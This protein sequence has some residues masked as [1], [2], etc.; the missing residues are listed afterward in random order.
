MKYF[1]AEY[2]QKIFNY[3]T[4]NQIP[5][6]YQECPWHLQTWIPQYFHNLLK[7]LYAQKIIT[8]KKHF[9]GKK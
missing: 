1:M 5:W 2:D 6:L 8:I 9:H 4:D 3:L 7:K